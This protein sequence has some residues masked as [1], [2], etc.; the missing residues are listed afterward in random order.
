M[1]TP[2][3]QICILCQLEYDSERWDE[4]YCPDC[5]PH[6]EMNEQYRKDIKNGVI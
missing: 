2:D 6:D 3:Q 1:S 4:A 5:D